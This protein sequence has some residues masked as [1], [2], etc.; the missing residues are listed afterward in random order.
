MKI[1]DD[2]LTT[3]KEHAYDLLS[4]KDISYLLSKD[5]S[6]FKTEFDNHKSKLFIAYQ[7][8]RAERKKKLRQPVLKL[9]ELGSPQAEILADKFLNEQLISETD[10]D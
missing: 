4:W 5:L 3:I 9:A 2:E 6:E 1:S 8:G 10:D 7:T